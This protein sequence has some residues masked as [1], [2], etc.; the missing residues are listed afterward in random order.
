MPA[1]LRELR[2]S[3]HDLTVA[4]AEGAG[5]RGKFEN[6][7][8]LL[9]GQH[10]AAHDWLLV[11]D[12]DVRLPRGFLDAFLGLARVLDLSLAQPAHRAHSHAAWSVT[13]RV[14]GVL[15]RETQ[16]VEIG[17]VT[18]LRRN[19]FTELLPFPALRYGWGL[20]LHWS[21]LA[22]LNDWKIG[23]VDAT[24]IAHRSRVIARD[25]SHDDAIRE[26]EEFLQ[27]RAYVPAGEAN[28]TLAEVRELPR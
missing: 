18:A 4:V 12:D 23:V 25:Y 26:A 22:R 28:R 6:L 1:A 9:A 13:R 24:P 3:Q 7:N 14:P 15:A 16:F 17:P 5:E 21:A 19:T 27:R 10:A 20:D 2:R 8:A 11:I